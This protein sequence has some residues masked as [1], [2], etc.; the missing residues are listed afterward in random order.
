MEKNIKCLYC[1]DGWKYILFPFFWKTCTVCNGTG[2]NEEASGLSVPDVPVDNSEETV[3]GETSAEKTFS[4][5]ENIAT[6]EP[7][8]REEPLP[9]AVVPVAAQPVPVFPSESPAAPPSLATADTSPPEDGEKLPLRI[10]VPSRAKAYDVPLAKK[11][12]LP[13]AEGQKL[14]KSRGVSKLPGSNGNGHHSGEAG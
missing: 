5:N 10:N 13:T 14:V 3:I 9:V 11:P 1:R 8:L 6:A 12:V 4:L 7:T 2:F